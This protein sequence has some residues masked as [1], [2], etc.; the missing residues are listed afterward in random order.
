MSLIAISDDTSPSLKNGFNLFDDALG[1][2]WKH[3][4]RAGIQRV[5]LKQILEAEYDAADKAAVEGEGVKVHQLICILSASEVKFSL[6]G[7]SNTFVG[8]R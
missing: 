7:F 2:F 3:D 1:G 5:E 4:N 6:G 8:G